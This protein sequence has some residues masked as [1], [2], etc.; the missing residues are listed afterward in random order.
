M[1]KQ[2]TVLLATILTSIAITSCNSPRFIYS[3]PPANVAYFKNKGDYKVATYISTGKAIFNKTRRDYQNSGFDIQGAYAITDHW[4]INGSIYNRKEQDSY[5][6]QFNIFDTST[7]NYKR[8]LFEIGGGFYTPLNA[9]KLV[10]IN[11]V[12]NI[13]FGKFN[14]NDNGSIN[15]SIYQRYFDNNITK[16]SLQPSI[17]V[18]PS[19]FFQ[20]SVAARL[21]FVHFGGTNTNYT[22]IELTGLRL[23]ELNGTTVQFF[24]PTINAEIGIPGVEWLKISLSNTLCFRLNRNY[25]ENRLFNASIGLSFQLPSKNK[26]R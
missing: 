8:Q 20:F 4:L 23:N 9:D 5:G 14:L 17:N 24:E 7:I 21:N 11:L 2:L 25:V 13:G 18:M 10:I 19:E 12:A 26:R 1:N 3:P 6:S 15:A 16:F 22:T